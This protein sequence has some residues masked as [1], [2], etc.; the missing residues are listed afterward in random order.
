MPKTRWFD[1]ATLNYAQALL[2]PTGVRDADAAVVSIVETGVELSTSFADLRGQVARAQNALRREGVQ[3]GDRVAAFATNTTETLVLFLACASLGA[4]FS[5]CSPDFGAEA[6]LARFGQ[7][8]P[9]LL[10]VSERYFYGGRLFDTRSQCAALATALGPINMIALPYLGEIWEPSAGAVPWSTWIEPSGN[11]PEFAQ[12]PFDH[13]LYIL[14][15]SGTTGPPKAMVHRAGGVLLTHHKEQHLH[16]DI[17][18]GDVVLYFSTCG[19]MMWNWL[20]S[21]LAQGATILLYEGSPAYPDSGVL[22]RLAERHRVTYFGAS[23]RFLHSLAAQGASPRSDVN[24]SSL[25]TIASTGAPLTPAGFRY[26]Y[27]QVKADVHLAS[28]AGGTDIVGCFMAGVPTLPVFAGQIQ[29]P[30]LGVDLVVLNDLGEIVVGEPGE[31][32]IR[33]P[34]PSMPIEFWD[35]PEGERYRKAYFTVFEGFWRHGDLIEL[36]T[37]GGIVVYGRS[38]A[39]L[40]PGGV[41][42]GTAEVYRPLESLSA[43]VEAAAVGRQVDRDEV[44]WLFVVLKEG[45]KIDPNLEERIRGVIR[46]SASPRHVPKRVFQVSDLPRT[47]SGKVMEIAI[48]QLVNGGD[49]PNLS[50][51]ANPEALDE[52]VRQI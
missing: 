17:C 37:E 48:T 27:D 11:E 52:I 33:Q 43:V 47:Q 40:N 49:V 44:I 51:V 19:W 50:A 45:V 2:Y 32:V 6:A 20:V 23:A 9:K 35:D 7:I 25:R 42:I 28:I 38:D 36:T 46:M 3:I 22:W 5:S 15:S 39:T 1:G 30:T 14:Y 4:I 12:L 34:M 13:P 18:R 29:G 31:L 24:L 21:G 41:R 8:K 10:F 26:V 16:N